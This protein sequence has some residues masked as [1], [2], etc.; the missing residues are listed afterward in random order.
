MTVS[1]NRVSLCRGR[2]TR[3]EVRRAVH[4]A[5]RARRARPFPVSVTF[6]SRREIAALNRRF[7]GRR[8]ATDVIAFTLR[9]PGGGRAGDMYICPDVAH[10][11]A[12]RFGVALRQELLRLVVHGTLHVLGYDHPEGRGHER[13]GFFRAQERIVTDLV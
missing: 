7:L 13:S 10:D 4:A 11:S 8:G 9:M 1:A 6:V 2:L 12:R 3:R 5:F